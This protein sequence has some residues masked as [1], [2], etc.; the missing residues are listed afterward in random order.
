MQ[1]CETIQIIPLQG[2]D[3][4]LFTHMILYCPVC[5]TSY[6]LS[7]SHVLRILDKYRQVLHNSAYRRLALQKF[8]IDPEELHQL[9]WEIPIAEIANL[10]GVSK[11][12]VEKRCRAFGIPK[13]PRGVWSNSESN[14]DLTLEDQV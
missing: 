4:H 12:V 7:S 6:K 5:R 1:P 9:V 10:Y 14:I 3:E 13:P 11:K 2:C 8:E